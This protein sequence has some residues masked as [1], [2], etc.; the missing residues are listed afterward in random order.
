MAQVIK[1]CECER[2]RWSKCGHSWTARWWEDGRQREKSFHRNY[3]AAAKFSKQ[4]EA[5]KLDIRRGDPVPV[6]FGEYAGSWLAASP[7][8]A[9][10][11]RIY[12]QALRLHL[13]PAFGT[14][15]LAT[16]A[17]DREGVTAF[18]RTLTPSAGRISRTCLQAL[19]SEAAR[20]GRVDYHRLSG[21]RL[22]D[23]EPA[24]KFTFPSKAQLSALAG[25]LDHELQPAVWIMRGCGL[26]P[27]EALALRR[28]DF[29]G[30]HLRVSRQVLTDSTVGALKA[31]KLGD[32]RDVPVPTYVKAVVGKLGDGDLFPAG[33]RRTFNRQ[34]TAAAKTAGLPGFRPH[35]LRHTF[36]SVA[37]AARVPV[38]DVARWLGHR[39]IDTTYRT[40]S[41]FIPSSLETARSALDAEYQQWSAAA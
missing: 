15:P 29:A 12:G 37:L 39:K 30:G 27:G 38:T 10:T 36:A 4:V 26:R 17:N 41:H 24:V 11:R 31:R 32:F 16:V 14:R 3:Q 8:S 6:T 19:L 9:S 28:E 34:F 7:G 23:Y 18:L 33:C 40:Y 20:A 1:R 5:A 25:G 13:I 21:I 35:D 22:A 2:S